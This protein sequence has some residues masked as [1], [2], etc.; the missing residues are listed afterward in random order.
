MS[1]SLPFLLCCVEGK[2]QAN[3]LLKE[4]FN[5]EL[6]FFF[7]ITTSYLFKVYNLHFSEWSLINW[8]GSTYNGLP[9]Y[10]VTMYA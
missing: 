10:K 1:L 3:W 8:V 5:D 7:L 9:N 6:I 2:E 4:V